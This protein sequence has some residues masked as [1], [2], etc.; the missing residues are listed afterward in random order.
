MAHLLLC[1]E[2]F[3][4]IFQ[5]WDTANKA[6]ELNDY[7]VCTT[8][9]AVSSPRPSVISDHGVISSPRSSVGTD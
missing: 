2:H 3:D 7:S 5:S 4:F 1:P 9:G 8:W 6:S